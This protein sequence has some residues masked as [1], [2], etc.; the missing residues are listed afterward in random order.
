[1]SVYFPKD[2]VF[3]LAFA[4]S[5][6][7]GNWY[8]GVICKNWT[9]VETANARLLATLMGAN[10]ETA[11]AVYL[12]FKNTVTKNDAMQAAAEIRLSADDMLLFRALM[13]YKNSVEKE[14]NAL[15]HGSF[16]VSNNIP[17]GIVWS[18]P[19]TQAYH[20]AMVEVRGVTR[21]LTSKLYASCFVY[22]VG[23]LETLALEIEDLEAQ[24]SSFVG[25]LGSADPTFQAARY[26]Q[27]CAVP[28]V[29]KEIKT[30]IRKDA[31]ANQ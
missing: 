29:A 21:D 10:T 30:L 13:A 12:S 23:D 4:P 17:D 8:V 14:R 2:R 16:G 24:I 5:I 15:A 26:P 28:R 7:K 9:Y 11:V 6:K 20:Q 18:H 3:R 27:L 25:Y 19:T 1:M 31:Q 22:L